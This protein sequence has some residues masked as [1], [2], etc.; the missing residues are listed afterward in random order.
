MASTPASPATDP[1]A[2][3][4]AISE[5]L[6]SN[7]AESERLRQIAPESVRAMGEAGLWRV[8]VPAA[9]G[10]AEAGVRS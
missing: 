6:Q 7:A 5:V 1:V 4:V 9:H 2:A 3:A 8:L 10:G